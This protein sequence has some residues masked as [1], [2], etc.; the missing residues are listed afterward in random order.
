MACLL[1]GVTAGQ[2]FQ[3]S[4]ATIGDRVCARLPWCAQQT[5][6]RSLPTGAT[7][8][9]VGRSRAMG[10]LQILDVAVFLA[11]MLATVELPLAAMVAPEGPVPTFD[12]P[13]VVT[14]GGLGTLS[15]FSSIAADE[16]GLN[17]AT[18]AASFDPDPT[19]A[20]EALVTFASTLVFATRH[21]VGTWLSAGPTGVVG[22]IDASSG[23]GVL[24]AEARLGRTHVRA[25]RARAG[26]ADQ[27][28]RMRA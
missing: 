9:S 17:L 7:R 8:D 23:R 14:Y 5:R 11:P 25:R 12:C 1:T 3:A 6:E 20:T 28:T 22:G 27:I 2:F 4:L 10:C 13:L 15:L 26:V 18:V 19:R 24:P 16:A 21:G